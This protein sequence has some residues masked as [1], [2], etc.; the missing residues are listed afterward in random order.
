LYENGVDLFYNDGNG[1][2]IRITQSGGIV[3]TPGSI[4]GL[5]PPASVTYVSATPAFVFQSNVNTAANLDGGSIT[6]RNI[7]LNSK[8][9]TINP[10]AS[11]PA[12]YSITLP[13]NPPASIKI[14]TMDSSGNIGVTYDTDNVTLQ[15]SSSLLGIIPKSVGVAQLTDHV[16]TGTQ[17]TN[18]IT[19]AGTLRLG[20]AGGTLLS[21][22]N[23]SGFG[24]DALLI[25]GGGS[26]SGGVQFN[27]PGGAIIVEAPSVINTVSVVHGTTGVRQNVVTSYPSSSDF[28]LNIVRG[29]I[30]TS[31]GI[32]SGEGFTSVRNGAGNYTITFIQ[33]FGDSPS[34]VITPVG[35]FSS[36]G[37]IIN[38][39]N[40]GSV[41]YQFT[42]LGG[43]TDITVNFIAM[44]L[45]G[46]FV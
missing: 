6:L 3:G 19:L 45:R 15:V 10:P 30:D 20:G 34:V 18:N 44:G 31:G 7:V 5:V 27:T 11:L 36:P 23:L 42:Q 4:G 26:L 46:G 24:V 2:Q 21:D 38:A 39:I 33:S 37:I 40:S 13:S 16:I 29:T 8:G 35:S 41:T 32:V 12:N 17:L 14:M 28:G 43:P 25:Q 22:S 9:I 1:T